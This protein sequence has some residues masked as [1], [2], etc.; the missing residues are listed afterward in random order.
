MQDIQAIVS[1]SKVL[2]DNLEFAENMQSEKILKLWIHTSTG[3]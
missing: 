2:T 1:R 3:L